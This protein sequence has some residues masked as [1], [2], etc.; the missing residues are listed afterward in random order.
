MLIDALVRFGEIDFGDE[1]SAAH[2]GAL[3]GTRLDTGFVSGTEEPLEPAAGYP[4]FWPQDQMLYLVGAVTED[5]AAAAT[6]VDIELRTSATA[7][8]ADL[9]GTITTVIA[10]PTVL[11]E[12]LNSQGI[13]RLPFAVADLTVLQFLQVWADP[14]ANLTAGKMDLNIGPWSPTQ[15]AF[16]RRSGLYG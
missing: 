16:N 13:I 3:I 2:T 10:S 1:F 8:A 11:C 7:G 5:F 14:S 4:N 15:R 6:T 9:S 12:Q